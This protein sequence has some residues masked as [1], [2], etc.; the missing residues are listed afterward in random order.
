MESQRNEIQRMSKKLM[1]RWS[2]KWFKETEG[3]ELDTT[4]QTEKTWY[5]KP[6]PTRDCSVSSS[7]RRNSSAV[8]WRTMHATFIILF[9]CQLNHAENH[10]F[11]QAYSLDFPPRLPPAFYRTFKRNGRLQELCIFHSQLGLYKA[12]FMVRKLIK[13]MFLTDEYLLRI[14]S[15]YPS[16][17]GQWILHVNAIF[18]L[19]IIRNQS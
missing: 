10:L 3:A 8:S 18:S 7:S 15:V 16:Q 17:L 2:I 12:I 13:L 11:Q 9:Y 6:K 19:N 1:E 5:T 4:R 14:T